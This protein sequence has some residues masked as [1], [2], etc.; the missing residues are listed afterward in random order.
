[1]GVD[2]KGNATGPVGY[3]ARRH[4]PGVTVE[5]RSRDNALQTVSICGRR[6]AGRLNHAFLK[7]RARQDSDPIP[8]GGTIDEV[9]RMW[10]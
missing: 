10:E 1:M 8:E 3:K 2:V 6:T 4:R 5:Q 9:H 7:H